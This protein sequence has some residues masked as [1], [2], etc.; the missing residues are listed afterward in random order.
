MGVDKPNVRFVVHA[1]PPKSLS[2]YYQESGRAGRDGKPSHCLLYYSLAELEALERFAT[3]PPRGD[4]PAD[5]VER[6][7]MM[8]E[9]EAVRGYCEA[10][11][12]R[13]RRRHLLRHFGDTAELDGGRPGRGPCCD[14]C[15]DRGLAPTEPRAGAEASAGSLRSSFMP[16]SAL[17]GRGAGPGNGGHGTF[18]GFQTAR[19]AFSSAAV[20]SSRER[21]GGLGGLSTA[22]SR[23]RSLQEDNSESPADV[24]GL[25]SGKRQ[26]RLLHQVHG[27]PSESPD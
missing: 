20:H 19:A 16:A 2:A 21:Q 25:L 6:E 17:A 13:C 23:L 15:G 8:G 9:V 26:R 11:R 27:S 7:A 3:A 10:G 12:G 4:E 22:A 24:P 1:G 14:N 18:S 5:P